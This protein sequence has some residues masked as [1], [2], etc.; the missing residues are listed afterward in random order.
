MDAGFLFEMMNRVRIRKWPWLLSCAAEL[1]ILDSCFAGA[2]YCPLWYRRD[3]QRQEVLLNVYQKAPKILA[4]KDKNMLHPDPPNKTYCC[5]NL[6]NRSSSGTWGLCIWKNQTPGNSSQGNVAVAQFEAHIWESTLE[7][8]RSCPIHK[9]PTVWV[10]VC[11]CGEGGQVG[12]VLDIVY[13]CFEYTE[14]GNQAQTPLAPSHHAQMMTTTGTPWARKGRF[15]FNEAST[16][17]WEFDMWRKISLTISAVISWTSGLLETS[18][19]FTFMF[20]KASPKFPVW[21]TWHQN[22]SSS[23][24]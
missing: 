17:I 10:S 15:L 5:R 21:W 16:L 24:G 18:L 3:W 1:T 6:W 4:S 13:M 20:D 2:H 11:E 9:L 22:P 23:T 7:S 8:L 12:Y 19:E 14:G